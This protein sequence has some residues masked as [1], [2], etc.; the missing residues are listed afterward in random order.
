MDPRNR[1]DFFA[2]NEVIMAGALVI[3][4][5]VIIFLFLF[6]IYATLRRR[7]YLQLS[8]PTQNS[9]R[10]LPFSLTQDDPSIT[11]LDA[12]LMAAL[13]MFVYKS[14]RVRVWATE[15]SVCL[16]EFQDGEKMRL[17]PSCNHSFH[18]SC[19]DMWFYSHSNCPLCRKNV[20]LIKY[21]AVG[22]R[23]GD[24]VIVD[25]EQNTSRA[26]LERK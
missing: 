21:N 6:C 11:G 2:V 4:F 14:E 9:L 26:E 20:D 12:E 19:I 22:Q 7:L 23:S 17:L 10:V 13:P 1:M 5:G 24:I 25:I 3:L 15:C 16:S 18:A 8:M